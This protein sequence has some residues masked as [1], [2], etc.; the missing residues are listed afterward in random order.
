MNVLCKTPQ[1]LVRVQTTPL[2]LPDGAGVCG[3]EGGKGLC[4]MS[5]IMSLLGCTGTRV[6]FTFDLTVTLVSWLQKLAFA[7]DYFLL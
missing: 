4:F 7:F 1:V 6:V 5:V 2:R 3:S